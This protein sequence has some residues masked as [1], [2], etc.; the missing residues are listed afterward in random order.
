M[1]RDD[2]ANFVESAIEAL[3]KRAR[4]IERHIEALKK[5]RTAF[6]TEEGALEGTLDAIAKEFSRE[7][8]EKETPSQG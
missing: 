5:M 3:E 2:A 6:L 8:D 1:R 4:S 7:D